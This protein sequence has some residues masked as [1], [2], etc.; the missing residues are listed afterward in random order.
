M[1]L[2]SADDIDITNLSRVFSKTTNSY[3][4][5]WFLAIL[6]SLQATGETRMAMRDL[7]LRMVATVWYPLAYYR[8]SFGVQDQFREIAGTVATYLSVDV[9]PTA[10]DLLTQLQTQLTAAQQTSIYKRVGDLLRWVPY[11]FLRPFFDADLQGLPDSQVNRAIADLSSRR[12]HAPY[13]FEGSDLVVNDTW[14]DYWQKHQYILRGFIQW[15]LLRFLQ[16]N[17]PNVPAISEKLDRPITRNFKIATPFWTDYLKHNPATSCI[18]SGQPI[19]AADLSIDHYLP[20]SFVAHDQLWN[21]LPTT[22]AVNSAKNDRLPDTDLYFSA[23]ARL[24]FDAF[25]FHTSSDKG[26]LKRLEDYSTLFRES[27]DVIRTYPFDTFQERLKQTMMPQLQTARN[28]GF[29]YPFHYKPFPL[30]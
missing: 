20:F 7:S 23:F 27:L 6:D 24:Q 18:Y 15:H 10:P 30:R 22:R 25:H 16:K 5:Y 1:Q 11:R 12:R 3:K 8:L 2:P 17:N 19:T 28:M 26:S 14:G 21:L 29:A 4:F 13:R 9:S